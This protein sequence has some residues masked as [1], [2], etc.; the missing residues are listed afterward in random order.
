MN[1]HVVIAVFGCNLRNS[2]RHPLDVDATIVK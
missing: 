2:G 1:E